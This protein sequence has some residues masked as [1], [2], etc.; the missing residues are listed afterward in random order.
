SEYVKLKGPLSTE[1][2]LGLAQPVV[3]GLQ[4]AHAKN[5]LHRD[6]KPANLLVKR[7]KDV[8]DKPHW[9][10]KLIDFGLAL[11]QPERRSG[12][13]RSKS[14]ASAGTTEYAAPEQL[15]QIE[16]A[17]VGPQADIY[18]FA[19]TACFALFGTTSPLL[20]HW[21]S[22]PQPLAELLERCLNERPEDR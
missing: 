5:I 2:F 14:A 18:S 20:K 17:N 13:H 6:I 9:D 10:V 7:L 15:S 4:A 22:I 21:K 3:A 16:G 19:K 8:N 12:S 11:K 1:E